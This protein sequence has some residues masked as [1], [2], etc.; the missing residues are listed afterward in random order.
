MGD[1]AKVAVVT[2][3]GRGIGRA[4]CVTLARQGWR[5]V[6]NYRERLAQAQ[7]VI[8]GII[9]DGGEACAVQALERFGRDDALINN[10]GTHL[11]GARLGDMPASEWE[12][13]LRV[14]LGGPFHLV[15]AVLPH[16]RARR[17]GH[18]INLSSNATQRLPA[19][20]GAYAMSK[21]ALE[22]FT[23]ILAK[24]EGPNG[25]RVNAVAPGPID[26]DMLAE[27]MSTMGADRAQAFIQSIPLGRM[28]RPDEMA[29][30]AAF[31]LSDAASYITGQ[32]IFANGGGPGG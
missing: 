2:G 11:P 6:V 22:A 17:S 32:T 10:A 18:I 19:G 26:T 23:R 8:A 21:V 28:G 3:G 9:A 30:V 29:S 12:R 27:T 15:R 13:I 4:I 14:N 7:A 20:Y 31:L 24:E 16:M 5:V 1:S 25:I